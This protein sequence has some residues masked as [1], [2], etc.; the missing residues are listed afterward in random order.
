MTGSSQEK[1]EKPSIDPTA[2]TVEDAARMLALPVALIR[3]HIDAGAP[4]SDG[5][6]NL[7]HYA[8]WPNSKDANAT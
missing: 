3:R 6:I 8:A 7:V 1:P 5:K 4:V 2:L